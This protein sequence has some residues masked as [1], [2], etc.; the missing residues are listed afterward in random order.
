MMGYVTPEKSELRMREFEIYSAYY[1]GLCRVVGA[2]YGSVPRLLL[3]YDFVFLAM[4]LSAVYDT[5]DGIEIGRCL[6]HPTK[7]RG[8]TGSSPVMEYAGDMM[9]L[10]SY[11]KLLDDKNDDGKLIGYT[12]ELLLRGVYRKLGKKHPI[13]T[14]K[15]REYM[16]QINRLERQKCTSLDALTEPFALLMEAV[17]DFEGL[18]ELN[19]S[20]KYESGLRYALRWMGRNLGKWIYL[21]DAYDDIEEDVKKDSYNP[22][23]LNYGFGEGEH[24]GESDKEFKTRVK[25]RVRLNALLYLSEI[26][27]M[28]KLLPVKKNK[29]ILE[30][31]I[32]L[33][34]LRRTEE[35]LDEKKGVKDSFNE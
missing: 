18:S 6:L 21:I 1:C 28:L 9:L 29:D 11:Y 15:I 16:G 24:T 35:V 8:I 26:A 2:K 12:G 22:L 30:N 7:K 10:L 14:L 23:I 32:Y 20:A 31:I 3:S 25:D 5:P 34:L 4:I 19:Y 13:K 33:G 17:F 27:E